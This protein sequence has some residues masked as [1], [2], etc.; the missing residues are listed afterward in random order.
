MWRLPRMGWGHV[1]CPRLAVESVMTSPG[2]QM[3][4]CLLP[5]WDHP[6]LTS[7]LSLMSCSP[8]SYH[9]IPVSSYNAYPRAL[10]MYS[11]LF[12]LNLISHPSNFSS[13]TLQNSAAH[14]PH[15]HVSSG[16]WRQPPKW[17][18]C[19]H[20]GPY[21]LFTILELEKSLQNKNHCVALETFDGLQHIW[22]LTL[23]HGGYT[24]WLHL[25]LYCS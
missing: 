6:A 7:R 21:T 24:S 3:T 1:G 15:Y 13:T 22:T 18:Q 17:S 11:A 2:F 10:F 5:C 12:C 25:S 19:V 9:R 16:L 14:N 8:L 4:W 20:S 23:P